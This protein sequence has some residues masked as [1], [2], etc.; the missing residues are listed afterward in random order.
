MSR[1]TYALLIWIIVDASGS[2]KPQVRRARKH[3]HLP[4]RKANLNR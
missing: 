4:V 1:V 3:Q 2:I